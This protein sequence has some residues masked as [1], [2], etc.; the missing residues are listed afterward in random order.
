MMLWRAESSVAVLPVPS[1]LPTVHAS[2]TDPDRLLLIGSGPAMGYGVLSHEL[3]LPGHIARQ[4][5]AAT[6]RGA[7][8]DVVASGD[9]TM[10]S[11]L[12]ELAPV[13]LAR[14]DA[15]IFTV[16]INDALRLTPPDQWRS[17]LIALAQVLSER[18][19]RNAQAF[20]VGIQPIRTVRTFDGPVGALP[21]WH[22]GALNQEAERVCADFDFLSFVRF[23]PHGEIAERYR[24]THTYS[25]WASLIVPSVIEVLQTA[26]RVEPVQPEEDARQRAVEALSILNTGS[27]ERFEKIA[28]FARQ[29][30][31]TQS[32]VIS[33]LDGDREWMK[34]AAGFGAAE[35]ARGQLLVDHVIRGSNT[36]VVE[37]ARADSR[38]ATSPFVAG[39]PHLR[40]YAGHPIESHNGERVGVICVFD[41][42]PRQFSEVDARLLRDLAHLVERE[43]AG[44]ESR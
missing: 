6:G 40:F 20:L 32:A 3:A 14:Y 17:Q 22:S 23:E 12:S 8:V 25:R 13:N 37:D 10:G 41:G 27:E 36:F 43:L 2:G 28:E 30:F 44:G 15:V 11:V 39:E 16:G 38:F 4:V 33:F 35:A 21:A 9:M 29:L 19:A 26:P 1:D 24:S 5:S 7:T 31:A 42:R 18:L 34:T